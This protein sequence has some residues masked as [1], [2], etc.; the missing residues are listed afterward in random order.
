ML[1]QLTLVFGELELGPRDSRC[2]S[3][4]GELRQVDK[5]AACARIPPKTYRWRNEFFE[6]AKCGKIFWHGTHWE[7]IVT[8][9]RGL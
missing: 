4:G 2:M 8:R 5:E 9:L 6:C 3:C 1:E 7:K